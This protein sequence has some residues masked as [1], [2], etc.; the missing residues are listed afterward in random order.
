MICTWHYAITTGFNLQVTRGTCVLSQDPYQKRKKIMS[1]WVGQ[2]R[3]MSHRMYNKMILFPIHQGNDNEQPQRDGHWF[4]IVV[5]ME[6]KKKANKVHAK[7][8]TLWKKYIAK[9]KGC[10]VPTIYMFELEFITG[11]KQFGILKAMQIWEGSRLSKL[12]GHDELKLRKDMLF[13]WINSPTKQDRLEEL[14]LT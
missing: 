9:H 7:V 4:T 14:S 3:M 2:L 1:P 5:N 13:E 10:T 6:A 12:I 8:I 11:F